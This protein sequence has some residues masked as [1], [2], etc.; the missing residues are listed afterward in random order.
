LLNS[1]KDDQITN[2]AYLAIRACIAM[3]IYAAFANRRLNLMGTGYADMQHY[4]LLLDC[5]R[6]DA[7]TP[8]HE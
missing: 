1:Y 4:T 8:F 7:A 2:K 6:I 3:P 5:L